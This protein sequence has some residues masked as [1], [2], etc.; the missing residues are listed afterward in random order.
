MSVG[1]TLKATHLVL[2]VLGGLAM[3]GHSIERYVRTTQRP[4]PVTVQTD[5][6]K[7]LA[8]IAHYKEWK[9]VNPTPAPMAPASAIACSRPVNWQENPHTMKFI[10]VYVNREA[11]KAMWQQE[12]PKFP[13][14]SIIVKEKVSSPTATDPELLTVMIK[15]DAGY[16]P[17]HGD[18]E[19]L[20]TDGKVS[21]ITERGKLASCTTCHT[22]YAETDFV[23]RTYMRWPVKKAG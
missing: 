17:E 21:S 9:L 2:V 19:Y 15:R 6:E 20:V 13:L 11:E 23:T 4:A 22:H 14:G 7:V 3:I 8:T 12:A 18:W 1:S 16:N 10:S 5:D